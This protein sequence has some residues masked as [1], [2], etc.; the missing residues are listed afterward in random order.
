MT[1]DLE[2]ASRKTAANFAA[3]VPVEDIERLRALFLAAFREQP[4]FLNAI[5]A[6]EPTVFHALW[7]ELDVGED[8]ATFVNGKVQEIARRKG[9]F[10]QEAE[11][12]RWY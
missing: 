2:V 4:D 11:D 8:Y 10:V 5:F 9:W 3:K 7:N 6:E 1:E 12:G